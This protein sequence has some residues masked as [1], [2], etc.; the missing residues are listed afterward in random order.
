M[1][2]KVKNID[3]ILKIENIDEIDE[4]VVVENDEIVVENVNEISLNEILIEII[5]TL[6]DIEDENIYNRLIFDILN[7]KIDDIEDIDVVIKL[8]T[9]NFNYSVDE[10]IDYLNDNEDEDDFINKEIS[11]KNC[12]KYEIKKLI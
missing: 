5:L 1:L 9:S 11:I 3:D 8:L 10:I 2:Y 12:L 4:I 7:E 6:K